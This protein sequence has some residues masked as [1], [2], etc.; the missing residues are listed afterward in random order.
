MQYR[1]RVRV[2]LRKPSKLQ[3]LPGDSRE[4][5]MAPGGLAAAGQWQIQTALVQ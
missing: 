3:V 5:S 1:D 2:G 4:F